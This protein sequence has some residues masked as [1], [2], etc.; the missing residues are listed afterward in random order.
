MVSGEAQLVIGA[1]ESMEYI[2]ENNGTV[3]EILYYEMMR[4][5]LWKIET[6]SLI[7]WYQHRDGDA[8]LR[9]MSNE[10]SKYTYHQNIGTDHSFYFFNG[11]YNYPEAMIRKAIYNES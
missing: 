8:P 10:C 7:A 5:S 11:E 1:A 2:D 9:Y 4:G 6:G 3:T